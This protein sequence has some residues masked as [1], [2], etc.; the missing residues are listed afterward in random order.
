MPRFVEKGASLWL[1]VLPLDEFG[2]S[3]HKGEFRDAL[4][5]RYMAGV[6][7][8]CHHLVTVVCH[9]LLTMQ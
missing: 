9:A 3:L 2:F 1:S 8:M 7:Q 6:F 4:C 5:L